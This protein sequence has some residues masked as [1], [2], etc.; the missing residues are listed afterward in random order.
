MY[1]L[2][3]GWNYEGEG[4]LGAYATLEAAIEAAEAHRAA[5]EARLGRPSMHGHLSVYEVE[6]G[7]PAVFSFDR[8]P[9][10]TVS[11]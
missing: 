4:L 5:E 2:L 11:Y 8:A 10:W 6:V 7:A 1:V 9:A 3:Q